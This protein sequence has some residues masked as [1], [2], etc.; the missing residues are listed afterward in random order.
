MKV[1]ITTTID[2]P[3]ENI[4]KTIRAYDNVESWNPLE[5]SSKISGTDEGSERVCQ[6]Q[7]GNQQGKLVEN[8][9]SVDE[10]NKTI[11]VSVTK[12]PPPFGGQQI[13]LQVKS[14][15][16]NKAELLISTEVEDGN[17]Q[18]AKG[19][20]GVFQMMAEGLKKLHEKEVKA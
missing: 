2:A 18:V 5:S 8:L 11:K 4:W 3:A 20:E 6:V 15:D 12:A 10:E 17:D 14:S 19:L 13:T 1:N 16:E 7:F 9:D